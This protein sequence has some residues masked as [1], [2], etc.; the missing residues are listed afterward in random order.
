MDPSLS[1][2]PRG[3]SDSEPPAG[4]PSESRAPNVRRLDELRAQETARRG[5]DQQLRLN[6]AISG[7]VIGAVA[8]LTIGY[9]G[10][11]I[12][13]IDAGVSGADSYSWRFSR[14]DLGIFLRLSPSY[15]LSGGFLGGAFSYLLLTTYSAARNPAR[16]FAV[17]VPYFALTML[18][19]GFLLPINLEI[20]DAIF[21]GGWTGFVDFIADLIL[22]VIQGIVDSY[23]YVIHTLTGG[24]IGG[25]LFFF[26]T[27]V[28][29]WVWT[30]APKGDGKGLQSTGAG[31]GIRIRRW[32]H[33]LSA[34]FVV[35]IP[36]VVFNFG[37]FE[38]LKDFAAWITGER[39][40]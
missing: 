10:F 14:P 6:L 36:F 9:L 26:A 12:S 2:S 38:L 1:P 22:A 7:V 25:V 21:D 31:R 37:P 32:A 33:N 13:I 40:V 27:G 18:L 23:V 34:A 16:W 28:S 35:A 24:I 5:D 15:L 19:I 20:S 11:V 8:G 29:A 17:A 4:S 30:L 39:L 3:G